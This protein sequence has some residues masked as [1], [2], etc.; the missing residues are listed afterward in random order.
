MNYPIDRIVEL[1]MK[2]PSANDCG[3]QERRTWALSM[4]KHLS[5]RITSRIT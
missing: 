5:P 3:V 1:N 4:Y 2:R